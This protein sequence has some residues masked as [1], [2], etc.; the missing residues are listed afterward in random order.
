MD[1]IPA[2]EASNDNR[3]I[4][5]IR[6][7]L[8][9]L[10]TAMAMCNAAHLANLKEYSHTFISMLTQRVSADTGLRTATVLEAQAADRQIWAIIAEY[11]NWSI[12]SALHEMTHVRSDLSILLQLRPKIP[13]QLTSSPSSSSSKVAKAKAK[14]VANRKENPP[15]RARQR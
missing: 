12:E 6:T 10:N 3:G 8:D 9:L 4:N 2:I 14:G 15:V 11:R 5:A 1:E 7:S 13:K